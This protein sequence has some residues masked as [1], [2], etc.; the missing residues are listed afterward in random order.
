MRVT[1]KALLATISLVVAVEAGIVSR[2]F[3]DLWLQQPAHSSIHSNSSPSAAPTVDTNIFLPDRVEFEPEYTSDIHFPVSE[4][5]QAATKLDSW[6]H[7]DAIAEY[8]QQRK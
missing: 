4:H 1:L 6:I 8:I 7:V 3:A 5:D 2:N